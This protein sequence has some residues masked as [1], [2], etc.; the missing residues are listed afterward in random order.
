MSNSPQAESDIPKTADTPKTA[1]TPKTADNPATAVTPTVVTPTAVTP[2]AA[3]SRNMTVQAGSFTKL[4]I[5]LTTP[6]K[7]KD[8]K[9]IIQYYYDYQHI[10]KLDSNKNQRVVHIYID[11]YVCDRWREGIKYGIQEINTA[12]PGLKLELIPSILDLQQTGSSENIDTSGLDKLILSLQMIS[13][14]DTH[15]ECI[16]IYRGEDEDVCKTV[17][18]I[19]RVAQPTIYLGDSNGFHV[20]R[21]AVHELLHALGCEHEHQRSDATE[22]LQFHKKCEKDKDV[23]VKDDYIP[24]TA[25]DPYSIMMYEEETEK[26]SVGFTRNDNDIWETKKGDTSRNTWLSELNKIGLNMVYSPCTVSD[27]IPKKDRETG[28]YYCGRNVMERHNIPYDNLVNRCEPGGPNCPAC[29]TLGKPLRIGE[30]WQGWSGFVYCEK[31][32]DEGK[33]GP[34]NGF[35]CKDCCNIINY[36][37]PV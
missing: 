11:L 30:K 13:K 8:K 1:G 32:L 5:P 27:Y 23:R 34:H 28:M 3:D 35:P 22:Y 20:N 31:K 18:N 17:S 15:C 12:A 14:K 19:Q 26:E 24:L 7:K 4:T 16:N 9:H 37:L 33:C 21:A 36:E 29:R 25:F 10:N 6:L 2:E